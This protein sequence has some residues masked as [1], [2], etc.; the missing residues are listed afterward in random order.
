MIATEYADFR[1]PNTILVVSCI[2]LLATLQYM[3]MSV[4]HHINGGNAGGGV[5]QFCNHVAGNKL[6]L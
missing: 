5:M 4:S 3:A 6:R 1:E 2:Y